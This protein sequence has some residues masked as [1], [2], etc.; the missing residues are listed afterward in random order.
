MSLQDNFINEVFSESKP[1]KVKLGDLGE[2][3]VGDLRQYHHVI[4]QAFDLKMRMKTYWKIVLRRVVDCMALHL[5]FGVQNLVNKEIEKEIE[6]ELMGPNGGGI[7]RILEDS[8]LV[9]AKR[10]KLNRSISLPKESK[11]AVARIMD[12]ITN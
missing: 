1:G 5:L 2:V 6:N 4:S 11:D 12:K 9:D 3:E 7:Q 10:E 8:L